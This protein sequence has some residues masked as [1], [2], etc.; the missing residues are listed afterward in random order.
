MYIQ[1]KPQDECNSGRQTICGVGPWALSSH[2]E[3]TCPTVSYPYMGEVAAPEFR[4]ETTS[5]RVKLRR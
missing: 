2:V 4:K 1:M 3:P 5:T